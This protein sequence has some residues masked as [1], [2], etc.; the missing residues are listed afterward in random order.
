MPR[1]GNGVYQLPAGSE[2]ITGET[3]IAPTHNLP[4][5]DLAADANFPRPVA[6]GGTGSNAARTALANL[7]GS[8]FD[9]TRTITGDTVIT[10]TDSNALILVDAASNDV[11]ITLPQANV[12][13]DQ[14]RIVVKRIDDSDNTVTVQRSGTNTIDGEESNTFTTQ[15]T[16]R[17]YISTGENWFVI[18]G[19]IEGISEAERIVIISASNTAWVPP[20]NGPARIFVIGPGGF[21]G[22]SGGGAGGV[23]I[24][25]SV[26]LL[27]TQ[28]Y[29]VVIGENTGTPS[30]SSFVGNG[31]NLVA[32]RG[33][34]GS[35][36]GGAGG[37]ASG[38]DLNL[39][40]GSGG[41]STSVRGSGG[42]SIGGFQNGVIANNN[43]GFNGGNAASGL[44]S[45]GA[46]VGGNGSVSRGGGVRGPAGAN[47]AGPD[48]AGYAVVNGA[49]VEQVPRRSVLDLNGGGGGF[50]GG[51]GGSGGGGGGGGSDIG[52]SGG[53]GGGGGGGSSSAGGG[54]NGGL[55]A[56]GGGGAGGAF[57]GGGGRGI[58]IVEYLV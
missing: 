6:A 20:F 43:N 34:T 46:G 55:G 25:N 51:F 16:V 35:A 26:N 1:D 18:T 57:G 36:V 40:G 37:T 10:E 4:I 44:S 12:I 24:L 30:A 28:T 21:G 29:N 19:L 45:G 15:Y 14:F 41:S 31:A 58:V 53:F 27:T 48:I 39:T 13:G 23:A 47:I 11:T 54:G 33:G 2:A 50:G 7:G 3:A 38:G 52:G 42:G 8:T 56:G 17:E 22:R 49:Y 9:N 32:N 5:E